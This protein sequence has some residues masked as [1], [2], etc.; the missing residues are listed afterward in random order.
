M[1]LHSEW[2]IAWCAFPIFTVSGDTYFIFNK[3]E[4]ILTNHVLTVGL[5]DNILLRLFPRPIFRP[6]FFTPH[7][8]MAYGSDRNCHGLRD[9]ATIQQMRVYYGRG[10]LS[11]RYDLGYFLVSDWASAATI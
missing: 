3:Y 11:D 7:R 5:P 2:L 10:S 8:T 9:F 4:H 1:Y 6:L